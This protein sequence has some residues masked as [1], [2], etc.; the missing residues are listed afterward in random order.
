LVA[1][2]APGPQPVMRR[3]PHIPEPIVAAN[4]FRLRELVAYDPDLSHGAA[5]LYFVLDEHA[6]DGGKAWPSQNR[7]CDLMGCKARSI[8]LYLAELRNAGL[9]RTEREK[10][11]G[12]NRYFLPHHRQPV[13]APT[14]NILPHHRQSAAGL[15]RKNQGNESEGDRYAMKTQRQTPVSVNVCPSCRGAKRI[16]TAAVGWQAC[17]P[18]GGTGVK[19]A[20]RRTA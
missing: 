4:R 5:R 9:V 14:G 3:G 6:R 19:G 10:P 20:G 13:T 8:R 15:I 2:R 17:A 7:L 18:C 1:H 16:L 11:G 12:P